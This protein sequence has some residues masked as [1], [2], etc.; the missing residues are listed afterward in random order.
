MN[1]NSSPSKHV[2]TLG[3]VILLLCVASLG[4]SVVEEPVPGEQ[5]FARRFLPPDPNWRLESEIPAKPQKT[6]GNTIWEVSRFAPDAP[7][8][9]EQQK[10]ADDLVERCY[11]VTQR[12]GWSEFERAQS[13]GFKTMEKDYYHFRNEENLLDDRILDPER[14]EFLMYYLGP[15]RKKVLAGFMFFVRALE[16]Q[17][18]QIGGPLTIWH[19]HIWARPKCLV[20]GV[21]NLGNPDGSR[22]AK[23]KPSS[24]SAEM[25][26]VW[27]FDNP[28]G[29]FGTSMVIERDVLDTGVRQR[30]LERGF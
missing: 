8:T 22:C 20:R 1:K 30:M 13:D 7:P 19:Y 21:M 29:R 15:D 9:L 3:L 23:G 18:P 4:C 28:E 10:L 24:R 11:E 14:P 26:H 17:G 27:L 6:P 25:L 2:G 16:E 12:K 5:R